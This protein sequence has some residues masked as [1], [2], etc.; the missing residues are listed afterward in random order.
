MFSYL[1]IG[2]V[3][4]VSI[5]ALLYFFKYSFKQHR[6]KR[7]LM[8]ML[9]VEH[10]DATNYLVDELHED[11]IP[12]ILSL[13]QKINELQQQYID[14]NFYT[15][16]KSLEHIFRKVA[17]FNHIQ[18]G[19]YIISLGVSDSLR[20]WQSMITSEHNVTI[21]LQN[22]TKYVTQLDRSRSLML[23]RIVQEAFRNIRKYTDATIIDI[24]LTDDKHVLRLDI[25]DNHQQK[26]EVTSK[27]GLGILRMERRAQLMHA[28][29]F[30]Y[31]YETHTIL[32]LEIPYVLP[33]TT[34]TSI[35]DKV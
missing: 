26:K 18:L 23:Y 19:D 27:S 4:L 29:T 28:H 35:M 17:H 21:N 7:L 8:E 12:K 2:V 20:A 9:V 16:S 24:K 10:E 13:Q 15:V 31:T 3:A 1:K 22:D 30:R 14:I 5:L 11:V 33:K 6:Q 25:S 34:I 32:E